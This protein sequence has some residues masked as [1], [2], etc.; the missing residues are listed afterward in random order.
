ML[1]ADN[2]RMEFKIVLAIMSKQIKYLGIDL[3]TYARPLHGMH[4]NISGINERSPKGTAIYTLL[5]VGRFNAVRMSVILKSSE[6][7][8]AT[9]STTPVGVCTFLIGTGKLT[10]KFI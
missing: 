7:F 4:E 2:W 10:A 8:N 1:A 5:R 6:R 9:S 3:Q